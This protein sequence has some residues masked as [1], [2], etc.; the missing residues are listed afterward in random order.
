MA[1]ACTN[2]SLKESKARP[3]SRFRVRTPEE[4][5]M[6]DS[7][8]GR[9]RHSGQIHRERRATT[10][11]GVHVQRAARFSNE[12]LHNVQTQASALAGAF[13]RKIGLKNFRQDL[14]RNA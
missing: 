2:V 6:D 7:V 10:N 1:I 4:S 3:S 9:K 12:A 11:L 13:G 14:R 5:G 8:R